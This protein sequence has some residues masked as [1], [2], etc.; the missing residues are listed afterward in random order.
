MEAYRVVSILCRPVIRAPALLS[1]RDFMSLASTD[2]KAGARM[3][4]PRHG[5]Y[6]A[7]S[8]ACQRISHNCCLCVS[9]GPPK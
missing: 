6:L 4:A 1:V 9:H 8:Y 5:G 2:G 3:N 7:L